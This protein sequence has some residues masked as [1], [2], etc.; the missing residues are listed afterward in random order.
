MACVVLVVE[1]S[2]G[3]DASEVC[4]CFKTPRWTETTSKPLGKGIFAVNI[5]IS[6]FS[7]KSSEQYC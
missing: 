3:C 5:R 4:S 6:V 7:Q 2:V 1:F